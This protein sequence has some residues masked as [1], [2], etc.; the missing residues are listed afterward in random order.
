[1]ASPPNR[2]LV[3]VFAKEGLVEFCT[4][5]S[6]LGWELVS[7]G[8]THAKLTEAGLPVLQVSDV[9]SFPEILEGRVKT[10]HPAIHGGILAKRNAE[11]LGEL[12]KHAIKPIDLVVCN[13]YP[14]QETLQKQGVTE[15]E[16][17]EQIDIGGVTLLRASAKNYQSVLVICDPAD[18]K[19]V[20]ENLKQHAD[21]T[22]E[23]Q[24]GNRFGF[25]LEERRKFALKAFRHTAEYDS[26]ISTWLEN[27]SPSP[28]TSSS[29]VS[30]APSSE[31]LPQHLN[32]SVTKVETL[33]Y[34]ENPHQQ[35]ALYRWTGEEAPFEQL[36]GKELSYNNILDIEVAYN[37]AKEFT[38]PAVSI[39]KHNTPCGIATDPS[40]LVAAYQ[41]AF[42]SDTVS[43]FGSI[44]AVN[45][46][47]DVALLEAIGKLFLE[48]LVAESY[49]REALDWL[50]TKKKNC[51]VIRVKVE[52]MDKL[53][54][55]RPEAQLEIRSVGV[56]G[57]LLVQ[58]TDVAHPIYADI[59]AHGE[60]GVADASALAS[61]WKVV[62]K[63]QPDEEMKKALAFAWLASK[64]VKSNAIVL[65]QGTATVGIG[66]GQPN[67]VDSVFQAAK[68]AGEKARGSVLASD[69]FFPFADGVEEAAKA[70]VVAVIQPGG[71]IRDEEV[72]NA[73]DNFGLVM[74]F[75]G[76][77][78]FRH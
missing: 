13:L 19:R 45:R 65:V 38:D 20:L 7:T 75:T 15:D 68:R 22:G 3:S 40:G 54:R 53:K 50:T 31:V 8:G 6:K 17:I 56:M 78:H 63:K 46:E 35:G 18:Y 70:G 36:S 55:R 21:A 29:G 1:M 27:S 52:M 26:A 71:S 58:T 69:A 12:S 2:A 57:G 37:V 16:I 64:H 73:A 25:T 51:R 72:I 60:E 49:T 10:L 30:A 14:F 59:L 11:H 33:R 4:E 66:T 24:Q 42:E 74:I 67:R 62:T 43:A 34:G 47:V 77:R 44:I 76:E 9:T 5:L 39:I 41:K 23:H 32:L 61:K 28:S 48:V